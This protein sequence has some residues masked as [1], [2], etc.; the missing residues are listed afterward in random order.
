MYLRRAAR[1][2]TN[3]SDSIVETKIDPKDIGEIVEGQEVKISLT[4]YDPP[5][6]EG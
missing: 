2:S 5:D 3:G 4:A 1:N 6:L